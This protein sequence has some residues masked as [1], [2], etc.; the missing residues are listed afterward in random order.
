[1]FENSYTVSMQKD[2]ATESKIQWTETRGG[3]SRTFSEEEKVRI[4]EMALSRPKDLGYPF[5][6]LIS[7]GL[8]FWKRKI[9]D[10][11]SI[12]ALRNILIATTSHSSEHDVEGIKRPE[13]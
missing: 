10:S 7:S 9:V 11:I 5:G 1:M 8:P 6:L 3:G 13:V 2:C 4:V 12:E